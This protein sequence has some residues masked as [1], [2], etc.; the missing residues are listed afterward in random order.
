[1]QQR[2]RPIGADSSLLVV[3]AIVAGILLGATPTSYAGEVNSSTDDGTY[4]SGVKRQGAVFDELMIDGFVDAGIS[5]NPAMPFNNINFGQLYT[6]IPNA[7]QLNQ[8][9]LRVEKPFRHEPDSFDYMLKFQSVYGGDAR[10]HHVLGETEYLIPSRY[11]FALVEAYAQL[12]FPLIT[13]EG[14]DIK[15]G[16][17]ISYNAGSED[18]PSINNLFYTRSYLYNAGPAQHVGIMGITHINDWMDIFTGVDS[19]VNTSI[20]WP[21]DNNAAAALQGGVEARLLDDT[22]KI[23]AFMH[24]GPENPMQQDPYNVGWPNIP[25]ECGC[26]PNTTWRYYNNLTITYKPSSDWKFVTDIAFYR[27]DGWN[28]VSSTGLSQNAIY[29]FDSVLD[30]QFGKLPQ[31]GRGVQAFGIAQYVS[32]RYNREISLNSRFEFWRDANNFFTTSFPD[33]F[34]NAN[35]SHGFPANVISQPFFANNPSDGVSYLA[36]TVGVNFNLKFDRPSPIREIVLRPEA[37]LDLAVNHAAP[38]IGSNSEWG[39]TSQK[40]I[41]LDAIIPFTVK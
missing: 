38:F 21:G 30:T 16:Q 31:R 39:R 6:D 15:V 35:Q 19:G 27:D 26:N 18:I 40:T 37:R 10:F 20:G 1:M 33:P 25:V 23:A 12:H 24:A 4:S 7:P 22:L 3:I 34:S 32:Y 5:V 11:Q 41:S 28:T 8:T 29:F 9:F 36:A 17:Y 14:F 2:H 13:K